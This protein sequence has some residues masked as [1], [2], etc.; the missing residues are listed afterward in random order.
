[1]KENE[2]ALWVFDLQVYGSFVFNNRFQIEEVDAFFGQEAVFH[3]IEVRPASY[4]AQI[5]FKMYAENGLLASHQALY[6]LDRLLDALALRCNL[7]M[8][9]SRQEGRP[10][11]RD[12]G[13][14]KRTLD[15]PEWQSA[16]REMHYL[17][18]QE[19]RFLRAMSS[20]RLALNAESPTDRFLSF[21]HTLFDFLAAGSSLKPQRLQEHLALLEKGFRDLWGEMIL[22]PFFLREDGA[23]HEIVALAMQCR[24]AQTPLLP[25]TLARIFERLEVV[26]RA[27]YTYLMTWRN[28]KLTLPTE[29]SPMSIYPETGWGHLLQ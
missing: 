16:F 24:E 23:L 3:E 22:W 10:F 9:A 1:M 20:Y 21:Y 2:R 19:P 15:K 12:R 14:T 7:P 29:L 17:F 8:A 6:Y 11:L 4:G 28:Q 26:H 27:A 5:F 25:D 18:H 13:I